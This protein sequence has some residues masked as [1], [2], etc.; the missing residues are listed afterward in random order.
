M[1][2]GQQRYIL[3]DV[4][5]EARL[6]GIPLRIFELE[7]DERKN[8]KDANIQ[9]LIQPMFNG[10]IYIHDSF[11]DLINEVSDYPGGFTVDLLDC[12]AQLNKTYWRRG[13][14][15]DNTPTITPRQAYTQVAPTSRTGY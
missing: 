3:E 12:L 1:I 10:E 6:R 2:F 8:A 13:I 9:A 14:K 4:R 7:S 11:K 15:G 5:K